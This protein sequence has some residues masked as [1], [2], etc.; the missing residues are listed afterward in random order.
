MLKLKDLDTCCSQGDC[1]ISLTYTSY[2]KTMFLRA[3]CLSDGQLF[4]VPT[5]F[6]KWNS[7]TFPD[8]VR[9]YS[10]NIRSARTSFYR[11]VTT[12]RSG[13]CCRNSVCLSSVC[14]SVVCLSVTFVHPTH[15][16]EPFGKISSL[17][18]TLA[19]L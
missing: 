7:L 10:L 6:Q 18:C 9:H 13:L 11:N 17:L 19:I 12:L 16:V 14:L 3:R 5:Q 4:R 15:G 8:C 1:E 2:Y